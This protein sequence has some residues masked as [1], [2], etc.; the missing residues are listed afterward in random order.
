MR[1][2][3]SFLCILVFLFSG[4]SYECAAQLAAHTV[5]V[6]KWC[7]SNVLNPGP[8]LAPEA[9]ASGGVAPYHY[10]WTCISPIPSPPVLDNDTIPNPHIVGWGYWHVKE[11]DFQLRVTDNTGA[12]AYDTVHVYASGFVYSLD[13]CVGEKAPSDSLVLVPLI[14]GVPSYSF[15]PLT[16]KWTPNLYLSSDTAAYPLCWAPVNMIYRLSVTDSIGCSD[17]PATPCYIFIKTTGVNNLSAGHS[18][19]IYP[20]PLTANSVIS[21]PVSL[22]GSSLLFYTIDG[23]LVDKILLRNT[24]TKV[25][26]EVLRTPPGTLMYR[27]I[28]AKGEAITAGRVV[29]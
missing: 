8:Y 28:D 7:R 24:E 25:T 27:L 22:V 13:A 5:K 12:V 2:S 14:G 3:L 4:T 11:F 17:T 9:S 16:Y 29:K 20:N 23:K 21:I 18:I 26:D 6:A 1:K 19:S 15:L 10:L